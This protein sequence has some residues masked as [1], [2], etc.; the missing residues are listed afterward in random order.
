MHGILQPVKMY[1]V[2]SRRI[3]KIVDGNQVV[4]DV[5]INYWP[6]PLMMTVNDLFA[7][8]LKSLRKAT[9]KDSSIATNRK[10][11]AENSLV[12]VCLVG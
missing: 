12:Q 4:E 2:P 9:V 6:A 7:K 5:I 1:S 3:T 11:K 8:S 10:E